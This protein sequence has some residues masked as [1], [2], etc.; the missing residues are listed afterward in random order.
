MQH[1]SASE[2]PLASASALKDLKLT[3]SLG[4]PAWKGDQTVY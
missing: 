3:L 4:L 2:R 1:R